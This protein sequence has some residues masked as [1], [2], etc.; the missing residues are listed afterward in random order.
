MP[1]PWVGF[2]PCQVAQ[3]M[4]SDHHGCAVNLLFPP[5][6]QFLLQGFPKED[7]PT[8]EACVRG[9]EHGC[10]KRHLGTA[11][12]PSLPSVANS[13][14]RAFQDRAFYTAHLPQPIHSKIQQGYMKRKTKR[15]RQ[16]VKSHLLLLLLQSTGMKGRSDGHQSS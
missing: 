1:L 16:K 12:V 2:L 10:R 15:G 13:H 5:F 3:D 7:L 6:L 4:R 14:N 11:P 9:K 8:R